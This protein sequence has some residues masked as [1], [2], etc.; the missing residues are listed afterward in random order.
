[1]ANEAVE[2]PSKFMATLEEGNGEQAVQEY[3]ATNPLILQKVQEIEY[4]KTQVGTAIKLF[5]PVLGVEQA[6][7]D[8]LSTSL[9]RFVYISK[10][11]YH[12]LAWEFY[13]Y[14]P[15][16]AWIASNMTFNDSYELIQSRK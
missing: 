9:K 8:E 15:R 2:L 1:M 12:V 16:D 14:K 10:H 13:I 3:F 6:I 11:E 4:L 5:G 7:V